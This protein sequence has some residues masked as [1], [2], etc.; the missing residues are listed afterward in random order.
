MATLLAS[1]VLSIYMC[2]LKSK[3]DVSGIK[4]LDL[5][6]HLHFIIDICW[7]VSWFNYLLL[8]CRSIL[9]SDNPVQQAALCYT[10]HGWEGMLYRGIVI[11]HGY[12]CLLSSVTWAIRSR[13]YDWLIFQPMKCFKSTLFGSKNS[14]LFK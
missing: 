10:C 7:H 1:F 5:Y 2:Y 4:R 9:S 6:L 11:T 8:R 13:L 12:Q 14:W 3:L